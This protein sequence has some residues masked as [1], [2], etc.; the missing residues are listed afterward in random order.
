MSYMRSTRLF[1]LW[2]R[3]EH[4][5]GLGAVF[6]GFAFDLFLADRPD[7]LANNILLLSYLFIAA[8]I[9]IMLNVRARRAGDP[10]P[11]LLLFILQFC[12]GGLASNLL[13]LY[14]RSGTLAS[15]ALFVG[16]LV[17]LVFTNE[18]LRSRY[19]QLRL[20]IGIFY[21]LLLSYLL[22]AVP[23][24][25]THSVGTPSFLAS[26]LISVLVMVPFL[27]GLRA[28]VAR[29]AREKHL[30]WEA[31]IIIVTVA[32]FFSGL[33]FL[34][35]IPPVPLSLKSVGVYHSLL[36]QNDGSYQAS[37]EA[38]AWF[39]FWRDTAVTY[40]RKEGEAAY[41]FSSVFAPASL[42]APVYHRWE[43][44]DP[45]GGEWVTQARVPFSIS[46][47]RDE[48]YRGFSLKTNLAAG[49]W[50]CNVETQSG[51]LIGRISFEVVEV[52]EAASAAALS[53]AVL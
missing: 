23:T 50:R 18:Y 10:E 4:H 42:E 33:Y 49:S 28:A 32:V 9:I 13:V 17:A 11:L 21:V 35:I 22:I 8:A 30:L 44:Q 2:E 15:S 16:M 7:S 51:A 43:Y 26:M 52:V 14:G 1:K 41:C 5:L 12:F 48:G 25:I 24:F 20:N 29:G 53:Q 6:A 45:Q 46:G 34:H 40:H 19:A 47:G 31:R 36:K 37:F 3:Y 39:V 38:P 27:V